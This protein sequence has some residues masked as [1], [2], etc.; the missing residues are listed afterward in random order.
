MKN[1]EAHIIQKDASIKEALTQINKLPK[2]LTLF[3][4]NKENQLV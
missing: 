2:T 4:V 3:V 1:I